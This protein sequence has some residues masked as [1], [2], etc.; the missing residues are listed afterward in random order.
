MKIQFDLEKFQGKLTQIAKSA[1]PE[2]GALKSSI[3]VE[4]TGGDTG[5]LIEISFNNYGLFQDA[6]VKGVFNSENSSG[7]G[8]DGRVFQ[9]KNTTK[10]FKSKAKKQ[11]KEKKNEPRLVPVGGD[12]AFGARLNIRKFGIPAKPWIAKMLQN[13]S[14]EVAKEIEMELPPAIEKEIAKLLGQ[15]K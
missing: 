8:Y 3:K 7:R 1:Y 14:D 15:I 13:L 9:Y 11:N 4:I 6:G 10:V 12:L 5:D 2:S